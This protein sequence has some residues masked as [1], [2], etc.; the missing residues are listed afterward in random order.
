MIEDFA[1][2]I[3]NELLN[4]NISTPNITNGEFE[5]ALPGVKKEDINIYHE[6]NYLYVKVTSDKKKYKGTAK[7]PIEEWDFK[8]AK[9]NYENGLLSIKVP[10]QKNKSQSFGT[11]KIN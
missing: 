8:N 11:L 10:K 9:I 2:S 7:M 4:T 6:N 3:F 1:Q 5:L